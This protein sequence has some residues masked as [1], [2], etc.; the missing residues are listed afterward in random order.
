MSRRFDDPI[1]LRLWDHWQSVRAGRAAPHVDDISM[2]ALGSS[3]EHTMVIER[4]GPRWRYLSVGD[5]IRRIYFYPMER[6][7]LDAVVPQNLLARAVERYARVCDSGRPALTR[8]GYEITAGL[9][10]AVQRLIL[11]LAR[12]D[13]S[14]GGV[15]CGQVMQKAPDRTAD[16]Q[17]P[18]Q[19]EFLDSE[20]PPS[21][22]T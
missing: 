20:K 9:G 4:V 19:F 10:F 6:L 17:P 15:I 3:A 12:E 13:G 18:D 2:A 16:H 11:P 22:A 21:A 7:Y 5:A 14:I 8:N 1:L